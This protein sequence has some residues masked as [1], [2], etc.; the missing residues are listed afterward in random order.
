LIKMFFI[1]ENYRTESM[2]VF[3]DISFVS[4]INLS[5]FTLTSGRLFRQGQKA[6]TLFTKISQKQYVG[7]I[8]KFFS[9]ETS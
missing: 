3:F 1:R 9:S 7:H 5:L 6:A 4:A 8:V 2:L